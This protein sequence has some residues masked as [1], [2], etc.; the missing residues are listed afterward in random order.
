MLKKHG[1]Y[2]EIS[3][4][5]GAINKQFYDRIFAED[6]K[7]DIVDWAYQ[8]V[9]LQSYLKVTSAV[10]KVQFSDRARIFFTNM[11]LYGIG[12]NF[13]KVLPRYTLPIVKTFAESPYDPYEYLYTP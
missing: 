13:A 9:E 7:N 8:T 10:A 11:R 3:S 1:T 5:G 12:P 4:S 6:F 2:I